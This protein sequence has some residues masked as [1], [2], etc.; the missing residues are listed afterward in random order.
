MS[1]SPILN[2]QPVDLD[3]TTDERLDQINTSLRVLVH[4]MAQNVALMRGQRDPIPSEEGDALLAE[5]ANPRNRIAL[6]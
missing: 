2:P 4:L 1:Y 6:N 3:A 5:F